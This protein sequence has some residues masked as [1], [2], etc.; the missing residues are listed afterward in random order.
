ML[1]TIKQ[2]SYKLHNKGDFKLKDETILFLQSEEERIASEIKELNYE[3][4]L[5]KKLIENRQFSLVKENSNKPSSKDKVW[6]S[7]KEILLLIEND[8]K[9]KTRPKPG[10]TNQEL[11][12]QLLFNR[13]NIKEGTF[14]G[15]LLQFK[16]EGKIE[17][18][19]ARKF[20][21]LIKGND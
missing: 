21:T 8:F 10:L 13:I 7:I 17:K 16:E 5:I 6:A 4:N 3:L 9:S 11:Y 18:K 2:K 15:Y 20:W 14:R 12:D 19:G 1:L